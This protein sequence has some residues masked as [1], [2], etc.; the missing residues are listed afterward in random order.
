MEGT[1]RMKNTHSPLL[2]AGALALV[3]S[4]PCRGQVAS[5]M[6]VDS[7]QVSGLLGSTAV[8]VRAVARYERQDGV[9]GV[10]PEIT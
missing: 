10:N 9:T 7:V 1:I 6:R 3:L 8:R 5:V 4:S 2:W